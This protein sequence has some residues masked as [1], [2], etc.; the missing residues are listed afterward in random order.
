[1]ISIRILGCSGGIGGSRRTTAL[2]I[3]QRI[4]IDAGT[5]VGDL[6][7]EELS[8]IDHIFLTH[9]HLDHS[10]GIPLIADAVGDQRSTPLTVHALSATWDILKQDLFNDRLWPDFTRLPN[11]E[12]PYIRH[13][14]LH[15][16]Q[17]IELGDLRLEV[18]PAQHVVPACAYGVHGS[19]QSLAFSGDT[20]WH[21]GFW[22]TLNQ[23]QRLDYLIMECSFSNQDQAIAELAQHLTPHSLARSLS[24]LR[25]T[26]QLHLTH[27][28]PTDEALILKELE[29]QA[30]TQQAQT[31]LAGQVL[32]LI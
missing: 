9:S 27:L 14:P 11:H 24:H 21:P 30:L 8:Q 1:M 12:N 16:G 5:G 7:L 13:I 15:H 2:L 23:W 26:P 10:L 25:H 18:L 4:L 20:S 17:S 19:A 32:E 28:K 31:L 22:E 29:N 6:S 3:N